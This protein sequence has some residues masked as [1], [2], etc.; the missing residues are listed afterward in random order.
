MGVHFQT[1]DE[2]PEL[3]EYLSDIASYC[4]LIEE[5][6]T[7]ILRTLGGQNELATY[8]T[9]G[10]A[11]HHLQR[12]HIR[13]LCAEQEDDFPP[14]T[15]VEDDDDANDAIKSK[16]EFGRPFRPVHVRKMLLNHAID[17]ELARSIFATVSTAKSEKTGLPA[18][19]LL[20]VLACRTTEGEMINVSIDML[21]PRVPDGIGQCLRELERSWLCELN[22]RDDCIGECVVKEIIQ[23]SPLD[24]PYPASGP[25]DLDIEPIFRDIWPGNGDWREEWHS[26]P[27]G[28]D[29]FYSLLKPS[30]SS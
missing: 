4:P 17:E 12:L 23:Q 8:Q 18:L 7:T 1:P 22:P 10:K 16:Y 11:F 3:H 20:E 9:I 26:L 5:L 27:L 15:F 19:E 21:K 28:T 14:L 6:C 24:P 25:L 13:L 2:G 29:E 30:S